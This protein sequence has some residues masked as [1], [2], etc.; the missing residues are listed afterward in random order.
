MY[1]ELIIIG[2]GPAGLCGG[3]MGLS[4]LIL[5][6]DK[7]GGQIVDAPWVENFPGFPEGA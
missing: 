5:E 3:R 1:F 7:L 6:Q 2:G 4:V